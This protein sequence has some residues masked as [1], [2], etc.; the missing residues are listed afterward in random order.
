ME[1]K[2]GLLANALALLR[3]GGILFVADYGVQKTLLMQLLFN[4]VRSLDGYENTK[5]NKDGM[6]PVL[7]NG[8]GFVAIDEHWTVR[9]P[10]GSITLWTAQK[11]TV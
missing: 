1:A 6:I 9:T 8:A 7:I 11:P 5:A 4:Q 2:T 10:S 3:P